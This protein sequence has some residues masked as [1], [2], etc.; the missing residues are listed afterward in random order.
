VYNQIRDRYAEMAK[1]L[2]FK[3]HIAWA[4]AMP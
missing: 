2:G 1:A 3:G 4:E